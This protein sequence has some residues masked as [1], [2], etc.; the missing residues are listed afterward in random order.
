MNFISG[1]DNV[2]TCFLRLQ[3]INRHT[4]GL[5]TLDKM[6]QIFKIKGDTMEFKNL[7]QSALIT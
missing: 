4:Y 2:T 6:F 7:N 5:K 1:S 3:I